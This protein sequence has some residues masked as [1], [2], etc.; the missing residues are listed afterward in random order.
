MAIQQ[1]GT[2]YVWGANSAGQLALG[3]NNVVST[4]QAISSVSNA[5]AAVAG[6]EHLVILGNDASVMASGA[7][8]SGQLGTGDNTAYNVL[9][10]VLSN[11][12][13]QIA[14]GFDHT[15]ALKTDGSLS[16]FGAN[17]AGQLGNGSTQNASSPIPVSA[18]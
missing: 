4:P 2:V 13:T 18:P 8:F 1:G 15:L 7:N 10:S 5:A 16:V 17:N 3:H 11:G 9:K 14:V 12:V 6:A